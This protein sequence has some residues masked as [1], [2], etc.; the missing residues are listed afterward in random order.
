MS[1]ALEPSP[2]PELVF[3]L[4]APIGVDLDLV[5]EVLD[6]TLREMT[7]EVRGFRLTSLM[8]DI[9][10]GLDVADTP[11]VKSYKDR[12]AYAN[13]VRNRLGDAALAALAISAIRTYRADE[14]RRRL[15]PTQA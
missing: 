11:Y 3:G 12:I 2:A 5:S 10:V 4:V 8:K 9:P 14:W 15:S 7:Y 6:Q 13:E 1:D